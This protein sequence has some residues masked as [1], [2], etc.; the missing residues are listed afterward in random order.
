MAESGLII[1]VCT[2]NIC[3]SP[4]AEALL[5]HALKA[6]SGRLANFKVIS[7]GVAARDGDP[8]SAN[9]VTALKKVGLDISGH[10]SQAL[11]PELVKKADVIFGM[12]ESHRAVIQA[13][14]SPMPRNIYLI[15]EFMPQAAESEI[16]DP[17]G[18]PLPLYEECRDEIVEA[19]PSVMKFLR[20]EFGE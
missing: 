15:R 4:M 13:A 20:K 8:P 17:Y 2:G 19:L 10:R 6:E 11:T 18:G 7:A 5:A 9:S 1:A 14:I 16:A 3:R 12:T